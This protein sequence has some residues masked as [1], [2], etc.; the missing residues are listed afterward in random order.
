MTEIAV[1]SS[2][3]EYLTNRAV[4][5]AVDE[6]I[7]VI[8]GSNMVA[9]GWEEARNYNQA[10]LM[11]AVVRAAQAQFLFDVWDATWG[12]C[13]AGQLGDEAFD[14]DMGPEQIWDD[15]E[16]YRSFKLADRYKSDGDSILFGVGFTT[17]N[18]IVIIAILVDEDDD[19]KEQ[20]DLVEKGFWSAPS[21]AWKSLPATESANPHASS[22]GISA[23][24]LTSNTPAV[25]AQLRR[26]AEKMVKAIIDV[27]S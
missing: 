18:E 20:I 24:D 8:D 11:A 3:Q 16:V 4:R 19:F 6:L 27:R 12:A 21:C 5:L 13:G 2:L 14:E 17:T 1:P 22:T 10:L 9:E 15:R 26:H 7:K 23:A 25:I